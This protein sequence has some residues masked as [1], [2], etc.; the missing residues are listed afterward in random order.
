MTSVTITD[1]TRYVGTVRR[2]YSYNHCEVGGTRILDEDEV[3][4]E[5]GLT[6]DTGHH[7]PPQPVQDGTRDTSR[8]HTRRR[9]PAR[10]R[11]PWPF[12]WYV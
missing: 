10:P 2:E 12:N 4:R 11:E 3:L 7:D 1:R 6:L 9:A 5:I 8:P